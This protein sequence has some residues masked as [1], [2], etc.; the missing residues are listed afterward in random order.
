M[1]YLSLLVVLF[2]GSVAFADEPPLAPGADGTVLI[3]DAP[4]AP[5]AKPVAPKPAPA[6]VVPVAA[7]TCCR[8]FCPVQKLA[9]RVHHT[10]CCL[11]QRFHRCCH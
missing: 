10:A 3:A 4:K 2:L 6:V 11:K 8:C 5:A 1:K 9:A 7:T